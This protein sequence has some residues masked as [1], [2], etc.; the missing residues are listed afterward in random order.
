MQ[1]GGLTQAQYFDNGASAGD[2]SVSEDP[3]TTNKPLVMPE[4]DH[5]HLDTNGILLT[6]QCHGANGRYGHDYGTHAPT[7]VSGPDFMTDGGTIMWT[8]GVVSWV[9]G[10]SG[11][12]DIVNGLYGVACYDGVNCDQHLHMLGGGDGGACNP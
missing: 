12:V 8:D 7:K 6:Q 11:S 2:V 9:S 4:L 5:L 10:L 1:A 3:S